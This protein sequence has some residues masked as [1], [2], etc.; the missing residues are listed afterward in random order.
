MEDPAASS[1]PPVPL[2]SEATA[3][4]G[5]RV[6]Q[7]ANLDRTMKTLSRGTSVMLFAT[8]T[9]VI[10]QFLTRVIV[11]RHVTAAEWGQF[12]LGLAL[13]SLLALIGA[14]GIPTATAR[15]MAYEETYEARMSLVRKA[16]AVSI[17]VAILSTV[18]VYI[19]AAWL[20]RPFGGGEMVQVFQLFSVS[21]GA[22]LL[23]NVVVG[24]F[25]GLERAEPYA[26]FIQIVNP[27]LFLGLTAGLLLAHWGFVG[28][29][30][31]YVFSWVGALVGLAF[32]SYRRL[33]ALLRELSSAQFTGDASGR[34]GFAALSVTLFG[35]AT[36]TYLTS[37]ADTLILGVFQPA[38][39]VGQYSSAMNLT[40][41]LLVGTG[42]VT[43]IYLPVTS[44][45][46]R[47]Q[48]YEGLRRTYVTVTRWMALL[49][50]PLTYMFFFYPT[51][52]LAFT[53]GANQVGGADALRL[54]VLSNTLAIL[55]GPAVSTLGGLGGVRQ[56][57][58]YTLASTIANVAL[59]FILIPQYGMWGA[60]IAWA[61]ARL[62]FPLLSL[63]SIYAQH[64]VTPIAAHFMRPLG[65][66]T[67]ILLPI[68]ALLIPRAS[69]LLL[70]LLLLL[71]FFVFALAIVYTRSVDPGD[72]HFV[73]VAERRFGGMFRPIRKLMESH[74]ATHLAASALD[75]LEI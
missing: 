44:R 13:A 41:L 65:V 37:Y 28:V 36:L 55:L 33:P 23:A 31:G 8:L 3:R 69:L 45:L 61:V 43:F 1:V 26:I 35:V 30:W 42:T 10:L 19:G 5:R 63:G 39:I 34:V 7:A 52:S 22:T 21:I 11:T 32:Y 73:R 71:P 66:S 50:L 74:I 18:L 64:K 49:A 24:I 46:R 16:L 27:A 59:C 51:F 9:V 72:L 29:L 57:L 12:N 75:P 38:A 14:F 62:V 53:F 68:Y 47:Q 70:P 58:V 4:E 67:L 20:A 25:Q 54:L 6:A 60:A 15:S 17:P 2:S 48:D 56:V 40:R